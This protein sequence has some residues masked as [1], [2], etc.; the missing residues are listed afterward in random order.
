MKRRALHENRLDDANEDVIRNR[1][2]AYHDET[3]PVLNYYSPE[4][5]RKVDANRS[6]I[7][8]LKGVIWNVEVVEQMMRQEQPA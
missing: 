6:P 1:F 2:K 7:E 5:I 3:S 4:L 8:V